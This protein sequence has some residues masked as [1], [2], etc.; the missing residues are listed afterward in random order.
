MAN[1][2]P[3]LNPTPENTD[4]TNKEG[5]SMIESKTDE[6]IQQSQISL[7]DIWWSNFSDK[8]ENNQNNQP[9]EAN[10]D[11]DINKVVRSETTP[12]QSNHWIGNTDQD[13]TK[14]APINTAVISNNTS[15]QPVNVNPQ[16]TTSN[17]SWTTANNT[18]TN[19]PQVITKQGSKV[20]WRL[21]AIWCGIFLLLFIILVGISFYIVLN[22]PSSL[23]GLG[24]D[25]ESVKSI[26][27][28]FSVILFGLLFFI[29]FAFT[30][31]NA[32]RFFTNKT[33]S[34]WKYALWMLLWLMVF[35]WAIW[36]GVVSYI[37]INAI[38]EEKTYNTNDLIIAHLQVKKYE[39][40]TTLPYSRIYIGT[41]WLKLIWP[42]YFDLQL[43]EA[44]FTNLIRWTSITLSKF[45]IDCGNGQIIT[46]NVS[47]LSSQLFFNS[48]CL[49][50][51]KWTY[52]IK[53]TYDYF[54]NTQWINQSHTI[55][56]AATINIETDYDFNMEWWSWTLND[57]KNEVIVWT[58][59]SKLLF[60]AQ[61][62]FTD[63][64]IPNINII[65]DIDWD[66]NIDKEN[67]VNFTYY[68]NEPK[69][70]NTYF[71]IPALQLPWVWNVYY[72]MRYRVNAW[73][74]P[75]CNISYTKGSKDNIYNVSINI[76]DQWTD[77]SSY[78]FEVIDNNTDAVVNTVNS[79]NNNE[80]IT[81][82]DWK[83]Y[84]V[85]WYFNTAEGK[86]W[87]CEWTA[88]DISASYYN[89][90]T[91][92]TY[93]EPWW[94]TYNKFATQWVYSISW[95]YI[96]VW[97]TPTTIKFIITDILPNISS[98]QIKLFLDWELKNPVKTD[99]Y[100]LSISEEWTHEVLIQV[101]DNKWRVSS[102]TYNILVQKQALIWALKANNYVW[103]DPLVVEFDA[104]ISKLNDPTDEVVYF[105]WDFG[106]GEIRNNTSV[107][108]I[109][110]TYRF[111][112]QTENWEYQP[113]VTIKTKK[114]ITQEIPLDQ[115][116]I[117][118][119]AIRSFD[120]LSLSHPTQI[121]K[122]WDIIDF[123]LQA[124]WQ[125]KSISWDF[126][127]GTKLN[128]PNREFAEVSNTYKQA[129]TYN[130]YVTIEYEDSSPVTQN[131]KMIINQ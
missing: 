117:V 19:N 84:R 7:D 17:V 32:Y 116:I 118:K 70:Y 46:N 72:L 22:N 74:I 42:S 127:D 66:N 21:F 43:N 45:T 79:R 12:P 90:L 11:I 108:K 130:I 101:D 53:V 88:L 13:T 128:W 29:W 104:S 107:W 60:D 48:A 81:F 131:I 91:D 52:E 125:I 25:T 86:R 51:D 16:P 37:K 103:F 39:N 121:A 36:L 34:R 100:V 30:A 126:G 4:N 129:W 2:D 56:R 35:I 63:L 109:I 110:H 75:L 92:I 26:L 18:T 94:Q 113:K 80:D 10:W 61:K 55:N 49:Y 3:F 97:D 23:I 59:P 106:D 87:A 67:K 5:E 54:D 50:I 44:V 8:T 120:V 89:V 99:E 96:T 102:K 123:A 83:E 69:L 119:R 114:W 105:T 15:P 47:E 98:P 62:I 68:L 9:Q 95:D 93:I 58:A 33:W 1:I 57:N 27:M 24:I 124:D 111:D 64:N 14:Q 76:D 28:V 85:V 40:S 77:I 78:V 82:I 6:T 20:N 38:S 112:N 31:L 41:P 71:S 122:V 115:K 73:D 65:W